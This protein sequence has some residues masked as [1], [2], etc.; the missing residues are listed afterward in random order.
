MAHMSHEMRTPMNAI[1][2]FAQILAEHPW[3][4]ISVK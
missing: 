1:L 2:G 3:R 4:P